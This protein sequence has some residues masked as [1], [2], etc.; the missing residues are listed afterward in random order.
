LNRHSLAA[1]GFSYPLR[2]SPP[3]PAQGR[4]GQVWGLDYPFTLALG[5][6]GPRL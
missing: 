6:E 1:N 5:F 2:L 3:G 4:A